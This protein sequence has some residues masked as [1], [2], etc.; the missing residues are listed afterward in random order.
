M[1]SATLEQIVQAVLYEGYI[2]YPYRAS[3]KKNR[4]ERFTFGRV[5]PQAY[6]QLQKGAEPC[7]M[8]TE[9]IVERGPNDAA[10]EVSMGFL[11]PIA[12]EVGTFEPD[13]S[14]DWR[15]RSFRV[16]PEL[17]VGGEVYQTWHEAAERRVNVPTL[18]LENSTS[19]KVRTPFEFPPSCHLQPLLQGQEAVGVIRRRQHAI[20]GIIE[21]TAA[22]L[23]PG[24]IKVSA[25]IVNQT[26]LCE[27]NPEEPESILLQ[28]LA[29]THTVLRVRGVEFV[30]LMDPPPK[31]Q[32]ACGLCQNIGTWPV[33]IGDE[34]S[35]QRDTMLS[36]PIILYDYPKIAPESPGPLFDG[37]EID[38]ILS[39]R[40]L[41]MTDE[42]K[43][44]MRRVDEQARRMLERT[45]CLTSDSLLRMHGVMHPGA[46]R[47]R[48]TSPPA[49]RQAGA[50]SVVE[51]D[52]F[53]GANTPLEGVKIEGRL[54]RAGDR[55]RI[56]P[57]AR[58]DVLDL[59]LQGRTAIIEAVE[60]DA[61]R[62]IHLALVLEDDPGKDLGLLRQP[63]HR[64][65][66]G[67][68]E[69]EPLCE[70]AL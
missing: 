70:E 58:A 24:V 16:V 23:G 26:S 66:Y 35:G 37:T 22:P 36:S 61:E 54:L 63:G 42:E 20:S 14:G 47:E 5:Y 27:I 67:V 17:R 33:L 69:V 18:T 2:L 15:Q 45:E 21:V 46:N 55:V 57:Q 31:H 25:L 8:L 38:E 7:Q 30:S 44:E 29:S 52:D 11:H 53:F 51:F 59:A 28:T 49:V 41:T 6:S 9:C 4:R 60:Q 10:L 34:P 32:G 39:L 13:Q 62:R 65:F 50:A 68:E 48:D 19:S 43:G 40:I 56:R 1:N 64:F 12:R 3:S